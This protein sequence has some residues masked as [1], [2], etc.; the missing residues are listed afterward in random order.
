MI[1]PAKTPLGEILRRHGSDKA[2][3]HCFDEPYTRL[4]P[5]PAKVT[6]VLEIGVA[7]GASLRAWREYFPN[8][9]VVGVDQEPDVHRHAGER[10]ECHQIEQ[11]DLVGLWDRA[12]AGRRFDWIIEDAAHL[13]D[14]QIM[15]LA[16]LWQALKPGG[17]YCLEDVAGM[18]YPPDGGGFCYPEALKVFNGAH[19]DLNGGDY[20]DGGQLFVVRRPE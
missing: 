12:V 3:P 20:F 15:T 2:W 19:F 14:K 18:K 4:F 13:W 7:G 6:H 1:P 17:Y 16:I 9:H 10:I 8:A 5:D 11:T